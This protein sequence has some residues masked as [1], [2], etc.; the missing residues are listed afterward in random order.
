MRALER[1]LR[2][3]VAGG[4]A[5]LSA[6]CG[7]DR[8]AEAT[9]QELRNPT[10][11]RVEGT[12]SGV[13]TPMTIPAFCEDRGDDAYENRAQELFDNNIT[14]PEAVNL[15]A[16]ARK[17]QAERACLESFGQPVGPVGCDRRTD[18]EKARDLYGLEEEDDLGEYE[19]S[20]SQELDPEDWYEPE[21]DFVSTPG[22][23]EVF[24][25]PNYPTDGFDE[26]L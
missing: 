15:I 24:S 2:P 21:V 11:G 23:D 19:G 16:C 13:V 5:L 10:R 7:S 26:E 1:V 9:D 17:A 22:D 4:L 25:C 14:G 12:V 18:E 3:L 6:T 20:G 8:V